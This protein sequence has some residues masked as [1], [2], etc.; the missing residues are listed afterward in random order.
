MIDH[1]SPDPPEPDVLPVYPTPRRIR[2]S[3]HRAARGGQAI[4]F[5][6]AYA[7]EAASFLAA[8]APDGSARR[9]A[10]GPARR[11]AIECVRVTDSSLAYDPITGTRHDEGYRLR[12]SGAEGTIAFT[13]SRG[14][15]NAVASLIGLCDYGMPDEVDIDDAPRFA[16]R[17][18]IEGYYGPPWTPAD[19]RG[20]LRL[21]AA[22]KMNAYFYGPKDDPYHRHAWRER[23]PQEMSDE[24]ADLV[25]TA[26]SLGIDFWYTIGPGL[27]MEYS[28][29]ED[30]RALAG[31]LA[32]VGALGISRFGVLFDDIPASL[33]HEADR[34][35]FGS[36]AHAHASVANRLYRSLST[37]DP[38]ARLVVCPTQYWGAGNEPY[39]TGLGGELDPRIEVFWTGPEICSRELTLRDAALLERSINRP[40]LYWDNYPVNDLEMR[41]E[42]HIGPYRG[43]DPHL[44]RASLGVVANGMEYPQATTIGLL[45]IADYLWNPEAYVP[46]ESWYRALGAVVGVAEVDDFA[47]FADCNRYSTLYR[48][49]APRLG[50]ELERFGFLRETGRT[51]E[52]KA[53]L[54]ASVTRLRRA[55]SLLDRGI[56]NEALGREIEPWARK[57]RK[58]VELLAGLLAHL[59]GDEGD[60]ATLARLVEAYR[61][62]PI[63]TF[64]DL[65]YGVCEEYGEGSI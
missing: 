4:T 55:V 56:A 15:R 37:T 17:G 34:A 16:V 3:P 46:E 44:Y 51:E 27:S 57:F 43:R 65:L 26:G 14:L 7:A 21:M 29:E 20:M 38:D 9:E 11:I 40:P 8:L 30:F 62:D 19:R 1:P 50:R 13:G 6:G 28:S 35:A 36:L 2:H 63:Y 10:A 23:Y 24:I 61:E 22:H 32:A 12:I 49:D 64:A 52:A 41:R 42:L 39:I 60:P 25:Q 59:A 33:Q 47:E 48:T 54:A 5:T 53:V 58:G 18:L 31:K 45:T